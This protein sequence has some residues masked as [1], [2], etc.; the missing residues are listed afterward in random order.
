[1][2]TLRE[3]KYLAQGHTVCKG[4]RII[5][6]SSLFGQQL[7]LLTTSFPSQTEA[8]ESLEVLGGFGYRQHL[9]LPREQGAGRLVAVREQRQLGK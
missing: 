5:P 1:M 2:G 8:A 7:V 9:G 4:G 6:S 3:I